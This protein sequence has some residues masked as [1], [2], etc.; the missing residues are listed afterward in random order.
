LR[1]LYL[2]LR[3]ANIQESRDKQSVKII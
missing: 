3:G 1:T 2:F